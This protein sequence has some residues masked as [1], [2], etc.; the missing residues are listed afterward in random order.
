MDPGIQGPLPRSLGT[1]GQ[2]PSA[3]PPGVTPEEME[4]WEGLFHLN[5]IEVGEGRKCLPSATCRLC[6]VFSRRPSMSASLPKAARGSSLQSAPGPNCHLP[7]AL[8]PQPLCAHSSVTQQLPVLELAN[9]VQK[10]R[11]PGTKPKRLGHGALGARPRLPDLALC[12]GPPYL[13]LISQES[14]SLIFPPVEST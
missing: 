9:R 5:P 11:A 14:L 10:S 1:P 4:P 8:P 2:D 7:G 12:P 6:R 3:T 13:S